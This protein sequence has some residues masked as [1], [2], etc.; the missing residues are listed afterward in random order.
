MNQYNFNK[1]LL[2]L[3]GNP[4]KDA[5]GEIN[6]GKALAQHL[7]QLSKGNAVKI[8]DWAITLNKKGVLTLDRTDA[9]DLR[10]TIDNMDSITVLFK[11]QLLEV[12]EK[13]S[14]P[15]AEPEPAL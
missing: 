2:D 1:P 8:F 4:L 10:R 12:F 7:A 15:D 14:E 5:N 3:E 6:M 13:V 11:A 9:R